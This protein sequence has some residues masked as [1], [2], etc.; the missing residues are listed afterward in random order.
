MVT[1]KSSELT[2]EE[3]IPALAENEA[4]GYDKDTREYKGIVMRQKNPREGGYFIPAH[5]TLISPEG[6]TAG[7]HEAIIFDVESGAWTTTPDYRDTT[8][9]DIETQEQ[10]NIKELG[11]TPKDGWTDKAPSDYQTVWNAETK[12]WEISAETREM[13]IRQAA[14][15]KA[16]EIIQERLIL[17]GAQTLDFTEEEY[18]TLALS[19]NIFPEW[20]EGVSYS[21][22]TRIVYT[23]SISTLSV[24][25]SR[26]T[27]YKVMTDTISTLDKTPDIDTETYTAL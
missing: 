17:Q 23:P 10:H 1:K 2:V 13:L 7:E 18:I 9:Y 25:S 8:W 4:Y 27:I 6:I 22:G 19:N 5:S 21:S 12:E 14:Q 20:E 15:A 26:R 11:V 16:R 3:T 24:G